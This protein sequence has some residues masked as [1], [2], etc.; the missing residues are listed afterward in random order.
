MAKKKK[1]IP[2]FDDFED[3]MEKMFS[4]FSEEELEKIAEGMKE[5]DEKGMNAVM[6]ESYYSYQQPDYRKM[7]S[8]VELYLN[9][10][11]RAEKTEDAIFECSLSGRKN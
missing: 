4:N 11:Y 6:D 10:V 8:P 2:G 7:C 3:L 9:A 5:M 1:N